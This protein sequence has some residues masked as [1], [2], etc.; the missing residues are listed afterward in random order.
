MPEGLMRQHNNNPHE[1]HASNRGS[2]E[3]Q[4]GALGSEDR[5]QGGSYHSDGRNRKRAA[6]DSIGAE[7]SDPT[8]RVPAAGQRKQHS[9]GEIKVGVGAGE[10]SRDHYKIHN[11]GGKRDSDGLKCTHE[12]TARDTR[13]AGAV[14][15]SHG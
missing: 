6:R 3:Q 12:G 5:E 7:M 8:R 13:T 2:V 15:G 1:K 4:K 10:S 11:A 9:C 14:P